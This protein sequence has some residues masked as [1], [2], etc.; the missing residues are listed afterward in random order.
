[1]ATSSWNAP[2]T[3]SS[4]GL[5]HRTELGDLKPLVD[6]IAHLGLLQPITIT[7]D[8]LLI[9][10]RRRLEAVRRL[11]WQTVRV[12]VRAGISDE[13]T[14]LVAE[15]DENATHKPL[16][17]MEAARLFREMRTLMR[18]DAAQRQQATR[19]GAP[20][21]A[22]VGSGPGESPEPVSRH[23]LESRV[24]A[25]KFVTGRDS[26]QQLERI[27]EMERIAADRAHPAAVRKVAEDELAHIRN[28]GG[29]DPSWQRVQATITFESHMHPEG[30]EDFSDEAHAVLVAARADRARRIKEN[31]A[32][33]ASAAANAVRSLR[34]FRLLWPELSGWSKHYAPERVARELSD[35]DW[36]L[37]LDVVAETNAFI[38]AVTQER[39]RDPS[40]ALRPDQ[41]E[42]GATRAIA[43]D[44]GTGSPR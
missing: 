25:A 40:A 16:A 29:V 1:M 11:G 8:G 31:R 5:R 2:S 4:I 22:E 18:E 23:A 37:F 28:G 14:R 6:S 9:C 32:K 27:C 30:L 15:H 38:D 26:H 43:A 41:S 35:D 17:P 3:R 21:P 42:S 7:P 24:Q 33:R 12:W 44:P 20:K 34:S 10:G 36:R 19:Y 13:L 39:R